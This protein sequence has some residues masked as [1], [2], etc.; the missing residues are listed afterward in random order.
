MFC[1]STWIIESVL[2]ISVTI[3]SFSSGEVEDKEVF[4]GLFKCEGQ[5]YACGC[6]YNTKWT[7][8]Q[9]RVINKAFQQ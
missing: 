8:L 1:T 7:V 6:A 4:V 3:F 2:V 5:S 9:L